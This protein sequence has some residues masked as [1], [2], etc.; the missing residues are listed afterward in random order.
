M[1]VALSVSS[2]SAVIPAVI[3]IAT[4]IAIAAVVTIAPVIAWSISDLLGDFFGYGLLVRLW[5]RLRC[6][7]GLDF[8]FDVVLIVLKIDIIQD[9]FFRYFRF[10]R[11]AVFCQLI[12]DLVSISVYIF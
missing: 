12:G 3:I 4:V 6:R 7:L 9:L 2:P 8:K 11:S 5:L 10:R 1:L